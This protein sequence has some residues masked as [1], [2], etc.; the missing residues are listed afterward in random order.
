MDWEDVSDAQAIS[1]D[2]DEVKDVRWLSIHQIEEELHL[3][4][5]AFDVGFSS[6]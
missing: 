6:I 1:F 2:P 3:K 4:P 5:E